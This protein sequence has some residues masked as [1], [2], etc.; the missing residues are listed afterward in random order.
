MNSFSS[1][2][3]ANQMLALSVPKSLKWSEISKM[4]LF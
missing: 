3:V 1:L 4:A 2:S